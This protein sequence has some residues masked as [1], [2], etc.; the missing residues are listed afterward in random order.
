MHENRHLLDTWMRVQDPASNWGFRDIELLEV[1]ALYIGI[2][3]PQSLE[4]LNTAAKALSTWP[5][6]NKIINNLIQT[7][8]W[9]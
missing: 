5:N 7:E 1:R 3:Q 6:S 8:L 2:S 4:G 9:P